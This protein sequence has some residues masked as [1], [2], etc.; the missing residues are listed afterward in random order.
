MEE[1]LLLT[2]PFE[3]FTHR[4]VGMMNEYDLTMADALRWDMS[5]FINPDCSVTNFEWYMEANEIPEDYREEYYMI[6]MREKNLRLKPIK[7]DT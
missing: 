4:I 2:K 6:Y 7:K 5:G 1:M 3:Q